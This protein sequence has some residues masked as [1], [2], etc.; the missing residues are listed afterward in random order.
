MTRKLIIGLYLILNGLLLHSCMEIQPV[1]PPPELDVRGRFGEYIDTTFAATADTFLVEYKINTKYSTK[2]SIGGYKGF[3]A[4][5]LL[6]FLKLPEKE[7]PIDSVMLRLT[8]KNVFGNQSG[9]CTMNIYA[10]EEDWNETANEEDFWHDPPT[11]ELVATKVIDAEDTNKVIIAIEDTALIRKWQEE[12]DKN[13][14]LF[15][16][17][18]GQNPDF[19]M[20]FSSFR[21]ASAY[22]WPALYYREKKD[23][24][25]VQDSTNIGLAAAIYNYSPLPGEDVYEIARNTQNLVLSSGI[26]ARILVKF[27][28]ILDIP[29][30][31]VMQAANVTLSVNDESFL[32]VADSN[33]MANKNHPSYFY[34]R[35]VTE[36]DDQLTSLAIDS[37]FVNSSRYN[38]LLKQSEEEI[39]FG[40][41]EQVKFAT[42]YLQ[43]IINGTKKYKWFQIQYQNE[44]NDISVMRLFNRKTVT[45]LL[46]VR[47]YRVDHSGI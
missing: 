21:T 22:D 7:N 16:Q 44:V 28:Q 2:L 6:K 3:K 39:G 19:I 31:I 40:E 37:S 43:D 5:F 20:E 35:L 42:A 1:Y 45:P 9:T 26:Q 46:R 4:G 12:Q 34:L 36:A 25:L 14:G 10:V 15:F 41:D 11:M 30:K 8:P 33:E 29:S 38:L 27:D 32:G 24:V 17:I 13:D 47:Y 18:E 23:T